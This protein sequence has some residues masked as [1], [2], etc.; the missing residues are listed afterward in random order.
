MRDFKPLVLMYAQ[1]CLVCSVKIF[2][3]LFSSFV[4]R[5]VQFVLKM[6]FHI[7]PGCTP[8]VNVFCVL[9]LYHSS[10]CFCFLF[11]FVWSVKMFC[12]LFFLYFASL[13]WTIRF[14][15]CFCVSSVCSIM[16]FCTLFSYFVSSFCQDVLCPVFIF[17]L[18]VLS[19]WFVFSSFVRFFFLTLCFGSFYVFRLVNL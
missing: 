18:V 15:P 13:F 1:L 14:E 6:V 9:L 3:V 2:Y 5:F 8:P 7:P 10:I 17:G 4:S 11:S 16:M 19:F 12:I